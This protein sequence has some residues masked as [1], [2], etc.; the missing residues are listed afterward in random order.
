MYSLLVQQ[1][2]DNLVCAKDLQNWKQKVSVCVFSHCL[3]IVRQISAC[4][5][6]LFM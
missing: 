1:K 5:E 4:I 2:S 3:N 6:I